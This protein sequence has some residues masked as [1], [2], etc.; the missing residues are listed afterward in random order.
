MEKAYYIVGWRPE[1][2][3]LL[4]SMGA[5]GELAEG[6]RLERVIVAISQGGFGEGVAD[7]QARVK[8]KFLDYE[9]GF[10]GLDLPRTLETFDK[11]FTLEEPTDFVD[12]DEN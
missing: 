1:Y 4:S 8:E 3:E 9:L 11:Y 2:L 7:F 10:R 12:L 6:T 5:I